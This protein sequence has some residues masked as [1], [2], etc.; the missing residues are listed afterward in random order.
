MPLQPHEQVVLGIL[1]EADGKI[2]IQDL[3]QRARR[4][5]FPGS[6]RTA[7][8]FRLAVSSLQV[9][10]K[11]GLAESTSEGVYNVTEKGRLA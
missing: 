8:V 3:V 2:L 10:V 9:L 4:K 5:L 1:R 6:A 11:E 7:G